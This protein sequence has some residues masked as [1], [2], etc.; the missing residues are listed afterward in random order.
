LGSLQ[1]EEVE[2]GEY[3]R[4]TEQAL[5]EARAGYNDWRNPKEEKL[6]VTLRKALLR[7]DRSDPEKFFDEAGESSKRPS[8]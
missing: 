4:H 5:V 1:N 6:S 8:S 3:E 2:I 7:R